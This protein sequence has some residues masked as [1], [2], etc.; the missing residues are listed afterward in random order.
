MT[1]TMDEASN[2]PRCRECDDDLADATLPRTLTWIE[3]GT[4]V[5]RRFCSDE[6]LE[7]WRS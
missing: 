1:E 5:S 2:G 6:C 7:A 3:D 4:V